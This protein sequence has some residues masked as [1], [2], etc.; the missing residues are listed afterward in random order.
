M[1]TVTNTDQDPSVSRVRPTRARTLRIVALL[2]PVIILVILEQVFLAGGWFIAD[3]HGAYRVNY[4]PG[5]IFLP[6]MERIVVMPK[7]ADELRIF[8]LGGSTT[9]GAYVDQPF[10]SRMLPQLQSALVDRQ[11][12]VINAGVGAFASHRLLEIV[13]R[14]CLSD[15]DLLVVYMGHNEFLEPVFFD[16]SG[17]LA[18]VERFQRTLRRSRVINGLIELFNV[19][20]LLPKPTLPSHF[21]GRTNFP[22]IRSQAQY[23]RC[24][25]F[26]EA[27]LRAM[28]ATARSN[29]VPIVFVPAIP[30]PLYP[31]LDPAHG[32]NVDLHAWESMWARVQQH[33]DQQEWAEAVALIEQLHAIDDQYALSHYT[34]GMVWL[35]QGKPDRALE[36]LAQAVLT[37]KRGN[38]SNV[39]IIDVIRSVCERENVPVVDLTD[40][41]HRRLQ[42]DFFELKTTGKQTLFVDHCHPTESGHQMIADEIN[43]FLLSQLG[44]DG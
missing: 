10:A 1:S 32:P 13:K 9:A 4:E 42:E 29:N 37:D 25:R 33:T 15:P 31:P 19:D 34:L 2:F 26:L 43:R 11:V 28:I 41:F 20:D 7:P 18:K 14:T 36:P 5:T 30:N 6:A 24:L 12:N 22:L 44:A 8:A 40:I 35:E 23:D 27:N 38:R 16:K 3:G 21:F 39:D 17:T